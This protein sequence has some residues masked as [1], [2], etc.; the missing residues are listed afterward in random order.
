LPFGQ[1]RA[2]RSVGEVGDVSVDSLLEAGSVW[3]DLVAGGQAG[4][5]DADQ[6]VERVVGVGGDRRRLDLEAGA[7]DRLARAAEASE[8]LDVAGRRVGDRSPA[9]GHQPVAAVGNGVDGGSVTLA[10]AVGVVAVGVIA[11]SGR[12]AGLQPM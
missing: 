8:G 7:E 6:P 1:Q 12:G 2:V 4:C 5:A 11:Q 9:Y 3:A 10:V